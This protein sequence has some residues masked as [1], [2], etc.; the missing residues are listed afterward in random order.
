[1]RGTESRPPRCTVFSSN[2]DA[3]SGNAKDVLPRVKSFLRLLSNRVQS[4]SARTGLDDEKTDY[5]PL[6]LDRKAL[7]PGVVY[8]DPYG[9]VMMIVKWVEQT[10]EHGGLLL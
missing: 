5:Y 2:E 6:R 7:R 4:G 1:D 3:P 8:A 9:H 10:K